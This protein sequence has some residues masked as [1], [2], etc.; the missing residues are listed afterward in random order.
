MGAMDFTLHHGDCLPYLESLPDK[1]FDVVVTD[2]PY[3]IGLE[4]IVAG[5]RV[6]RA[7]SGDF[8]WDEGRVSPNVVAEMIRVS[9]HQ[10]I[11]GGNYYADLLAP[12]PGWIVWDKNQGLR[13]S[14]CELAW[15][16]YKRALRMFRWTWSGAVRQQPEQRYHPTQKPLALMKWVLENYTEPGMTVLDPFCGSGT[17]GVACIQMGRVF[18]G[19]EM[20]AGYF[21]AAKMRCEAAQNQGVLDLA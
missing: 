19:I 12:S 9:H 13:F 3:G 4:N 6:D 8:V 20:D 11:F 7:V 10:I 21:A 5:R 18:T 17:T 15:T 14:D 2:P 1:A 16:S